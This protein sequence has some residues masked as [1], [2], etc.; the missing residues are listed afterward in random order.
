MKRHVPN[1]FNAAQA[2]RLLNRK[3]TTRDRLR[4]KRIDAIVAVA[5]KLFVQE[6]AAGFSM[7][8]VANLAGVTLSTLQHYFGKGENLLKITIDSI[9]ANYADRTRMIGQDVSLSAR[10]RLEMI[11][12]ETVSLAKEPTVVTYYYELFVLAAKDAGVAQLFQEVYVAYHGVVAT[13]IAE[14]NPKLTRERAATIALMI[15]AHIDGVGNFQYVRAVPP[16]LGTSD[17]IAAAMK[18]FWLREIFRPAPPIGDGD[19]RTDS[20]SPESVSHDPEHLDASGLKRAN[21][22]E[23]RTPQMRGSRRKRHDA[24]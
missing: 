11:I 24:E 5:T 22:R 21:A 19:S 16:I 9:F 4:E 3:E 14:I 18:D 15:C 20:G 6:G 8:R 13:L 10:Q 12:D 7:R 2:A 17:Q 23:N 1:S